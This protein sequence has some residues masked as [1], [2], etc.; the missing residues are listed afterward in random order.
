MTVAEAG[1]FMGDCFVPR[2]D[3]RYC[4]D[5]C[6]VPRNDDSG[7]L[8]LYGR[9]LCSPALG[10]GKRHGRAVSSLRA[11]TRNLSIHL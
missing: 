8:R 7:R 2:N 10:V 3:G 6:L 1:G 5:D 11:L 4:M 9:L